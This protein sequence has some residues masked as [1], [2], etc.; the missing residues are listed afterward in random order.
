M[1]KLFHILAHLPP[2]NDEE[3]LAFKVGKDHCCFVV[4]GPDGKQLYELAYYTV[5]EINENFLNQLLVLHPELSQ[6]F[7]KILVSY[8][9]SGNVLIPA[10]NFKSENAPLLLNTLHGLSNRSVVLV[11]SVLE[12]E[13]YSVYAVP[14][15]VHDWILTKFP[16][17][18]Y[19]HSYDWGVKILPGDNDVGCIWVDFSTESFSA[20]IS[21]GEQLLLAQTFPYSTPDDVMY[22]LLKACQQFSVSPLE[23][24]LVLSG[25][26]EK[27]STL[28]HELY[29]YFI[30]TKFKNAD[31]TMNEDNE[32]PLHFFAFL[33][34]IIQ[35]GS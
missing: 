5:D 13:V 10:L 33:N 27:Q 28:F 15:E 31:W 29:Q 18:I 22:Y 30:N 9:H 1:K 24:K 8:D 16:T 17:A 19:S 21:K 11:E 25:L 6:S 12:N 23:V 26:I 2:W 3:V 32:Y 20:F 35:C 7:K 4:T 14:K 34:G